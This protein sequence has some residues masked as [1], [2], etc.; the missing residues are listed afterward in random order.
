MSG[1]R[2]N[3][4]LALYDVGMSYL[5][6]GEPLESIKAYAKAL[7]VNLELQDVD[8]AL[9]S[10]GKIASNK[11]VIGCDW[12]KKLLLTNLAAKFSEMDAGKTALQ[13]LKKLVSKPYYPF[14]SP[15][16]IVAGV[17]ALKLK[18]KCVRMKNLF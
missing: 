17:A 8:N 16:V 5:L 1:N 15:V 11:E 7:Q 12:I 6:S 4:S 14:E 2:V 9:D 3:N 13:H 18:Q 10:I